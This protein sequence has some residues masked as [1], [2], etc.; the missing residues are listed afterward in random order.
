M[1]RRAVE[2]RGGEGSSRLFL[3]RFHRRERRVAAGVE[4]FQGKAW[5][6]GDSGAVRGTAE[7]LREWAKRR[8]LPS[9]QGKKESAT[10]RERN[11]KMSFRPDGGDDFPI[12]SVR[13]PGESSAVEEPGR[14][15]PSRIRVRPEGSGFPPTEGPSPTRESARLPGGKTSLPQYRSAGCPF[16]SRH[17]NRLRAIG[18]EWSVRFPAGRGRRPKRARNPCNPNHPPT[19]HQPHQ[20]H[21]NDPLPHIRL[22]RPRFVPNPHPY[23]PSQRALTET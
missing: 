12:L 21:S 5:G 7:L 16:S 17:G 13:R 14:R 1:R 10:G 9:D 8:D 3:T 4:S 19:Q 22:P 18:I 11:Q 15:A 23:P 2:G 6:G 20:L